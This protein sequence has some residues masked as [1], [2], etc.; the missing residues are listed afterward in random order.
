MPLEYSYKLRLACG[1]TSV[2]D[3]DSDP[4]QTL[5]EK[6]RSKTG[7]IIAPRLFLYLVAA[8]DTS[9]ENRRSITVPFSGTGRPRMRFSGRRISASGRGKRSAGAGRH[10]V[11]HQGWILLRGGCP[12]QRYPGAGRKGTGSDDRNAVAALFFRLVQ[13]LIGG[14]D[15]EHRLVLPGRLEGAAPQADGDVPGGS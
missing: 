8:G 11:D 3:V 9:D 6:R 13:G 2:L 12:P 5:V 7:E 14:M 10:Q 15:E 1:Q 4:R